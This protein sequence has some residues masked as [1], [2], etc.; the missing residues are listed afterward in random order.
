MNHE[1]LDTRTLRSLSKD[2]L[3]KL[4]SDLQLRIALEDRGIPNLEVDYKYLLESASDV[5]FVLD[6][7]GNLVYQNA[8]WQNL[9]PF[10]REDALGMH[11]SLSIPAIELDRASTIF[12]AV[13]KG[14][15]E[16][17][18]ER[19]KTLDKFGNEIYLSANLSPI[20]SGSGTP[21]GLIGIL[22]NV[23]DMHLMEKKLRENSRRLEEKIKEQISQAEELR[24]LTALNEDII[25]NA[26]IGIFTMDPTGIILSEN[27]AFKAI[28]GADS[29]TTGIGADVTRLPGFRG[30][31][32]GR[33]LD[34]VMLKGRPH[35]LKNISYT[36]TG[37]P[38]DG[39][40]L[41]LT[42]TPILDGEKKVKSIL[43]MVEDVSEAA[44]I[45]KRIHRAE[46]L[47]SMG[48]LAAGVAYELKM[49]LNLM[50]MDLGFI[51]NNISEDSPMR[52][53]LKS[54]KDELARVKQI[55]QQLL[56]LS[57]PPEEEKEVFE[58]HKL[59]TSHPIQIVLNRMQKNG[60]SV[61]TG[62]PEISVSVKGIKNQLTQVLLHIIANAEDA[63][64]DGGE[65][66]ITVDSTEHHGQTYATIT[67]E[68]TG[69]GIS[70]ENI[71]KV[72]RPFFTT[73][74]DKSTGLGMMVSSSIIENHGG[75]IGI[76]STPGEGTSI[77]IILPAAGE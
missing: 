1:S 23:T 5:I 7:N 67:L 22:R 53:Y 77:R 59:V 55:I 47:S 42:L 10:K 26:P 48:L 3:I 21:L 41:N 9:L 54:M 45:G 56:N 39:K 62:Y 74:G 60:Y 71:N 58:I 18:N 73:K 65:L 2:E 57:R 68:D 49:P 8:A 29:A 38:D 15:K 32:F 12:E 20:R 40:T 27:P 75:S 72:C 52:D 37:A 69:M 51:E 50:T 46:Q 63:M 35:K 61:I 64:P 44:R 11:Y 28:V 33:I 4:I 6:N 30:E 13:I 16:I 25:A 17:R 34:D 66:K 76:K 36:P 31:E 24:Q 70:P 19:F 43:V 14:E